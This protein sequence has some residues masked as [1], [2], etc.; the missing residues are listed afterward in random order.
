MTI[1]ALSCLCLSVGLAITASTPDVPQRLAVVVPA[2]AGDLPRAVAALDRWPK[3]C[4][5]VTLANVDL[6]LY[7]A[8]GEG[9]TEPLA[10]L[11][12]VASSAGSCF[13]NTKLVYANLTPEEDVYPKGPSVQFYKMFT[14]EA[15]KASLEE[16]DALAIIEWDVLVASDRSFAELYRAAFNNAEDFWLYRAAFNNAEDFWVK[17]S[18]LE[19]TNFHTAMAESSDMWHVMGHIN[20]NAIYNNN[21]AMF[22]EFVEYTLTRWNYQYPYDVA[23]WA[24]IADF[25]YS[26]PLWQRFSSKFVTTN[27]ISNVGY[28]H[29]DSRSVSD[30]VAGETL[31]IHGSSVDNGNLAALKAISASATGGS[32]ASLCH[33]ACG[34]DAATLV[35]GTSA[36]CDPTC[37]ASGSR[38]DGYLCGAGDSAKFGGM[39]RLCYTDVAE[40]REA[41]S[42][43]ADGLHVIMCDTKLPPAAAD[44]SDECRL[45]K[46]TV[47]DEACG[48][49]VHG[50]YNC[51]WR[52]LGPKCRF[53]FNDV[54]TAL[55]ADEVAKRDGG[56]AVMCDT[57]EPPID[58]ASVTEG[59]APAATTSHR[60]T[61]VGEQTAA[62][63][64]LAEEV[65]KRKRTQKWKN[66][67]DREPE[68]QK[69]QRWK[70]NRHESPAGP[71]SVTEVVAPA[72]SMSRRLTVDVEQSAATRNLGSWKNWRR[73]RSKKNRCDEGCKR[74]NRDGTKGRVCDETCKT[75]D[76]YGTR[77][78]NAKQG[79][80]GRY[81]R[82]CFIDVELAKA[83]DTPEN[84][85]I[86]CD[87]VRPPSAYDSPRR[88]ASFAKVAEKPATAVGADESGPE[89][90]M[91]RS[92]EMAYTEGVK[93]G[94][95]CVFIEGHADRVLQTEAAVQ[96]VLE[97]VPG[98]RV[99]VAAEQDS[100]GAYEWKLGFHTWS[101]NGVRVSSTPNARLSSL[102]A[103]QHCG[104][105]TKLIL[106]LQAS[107]VLSRGFTSKDTHT[108]RGELLVVYG[109]ARQSYL[110]A[111]IARETAA[112]LGFD[113]PSF[114]F[115][116]DLM[117]PVG[118]NAELRAELDA[119]PLS[120]EELDNIVS[121]PQLLAAHSYAQDT[122]GVRFVDPQAWV[123][124]NLFKVTSVWDIPLMKPRFAC[125]IPTPSALPNDDEVRA[126]ALKRSLEFFR[127]GGSCD[128]GLVAL[129]PQQL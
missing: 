79:K 123:T 110:D 9:D 93:R 80:Y 111:D 100:L 98:V 3:T 16:Y 34:S 91:R 66:G 105:G 30:A 74:I 6:V 2:H 36:V 52:G 45:E 101:S 40:A 42:K 62:T 65:R 29:V 44:C 39:C 20:G 122:D 1:H 107:S 87:T 92:A 121:V 69:N 71:V 102:F 47:C 104:E 25:P 31:F 70:K 63:R 13:G 118:A 51:D 117:L 88:L 10:A 11:D 18:N 67:V 103:D 49:G 37:T 114:T 106:Y 24:T 85:V 4:S 125:A 76:P 128:N 97:F 5:P 77:G 78:C 53:C 58:P 50:D 43:L 112:V 22:R 15:V 26:W 59:V 17:G 94:E 14:D 57:H 129:N 8:E 28:E 109:D 35:Q 124:Q 19:G 119:S 113:A 32:D 96:S 75:G 73:K 60:F 120:E 12:V 23:L 46:D 89:A 33:K 82:R 54:E 48:T 55:A 83:A 7:Y 95:I 126:G 116:T 68:W 61:A 81:C 27:L 127:R 86:M 56:R 72:A 21:D 99:A 41:E 38:F 115:G 90:L 64:D 108:P 84:P